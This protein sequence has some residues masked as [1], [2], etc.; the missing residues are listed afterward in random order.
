MV[1]NSEHSRADSGNLLQSPI[2]RTSVSFDAQENIILIR[3]N[4]QWERRKAES[5]GVDRVAGRKRLGEFYRPVCR[6][7]ISCRTR[8][9]KKSGDMIPEKGL[10]SS[11]MTEFDENIGMMLKTLEEPG[12]RE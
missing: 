2:E 5:S 1:P 6:K 3:K 9:Q 11:G 4:W 10:Y 8:L 7:A 12:D